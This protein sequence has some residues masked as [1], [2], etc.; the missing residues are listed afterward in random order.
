MQVLNASNRHSRRECWERKGAI[1]ND[2]AFH[3]NSIPRQER[4]NAASQQ[5]NSTGPKPQNQ[6]GKPWSPHKSDLNAV[7]SGLT[8]CPSAFRRNT[9][10]TRMLGTGHTASQSS[11]ES[12]GE[13]SLLS[14]SEDALSTMENT[15]YSRVCLCQNHKTSQCTLLCSKMINTFMSFWKTDYWRFPTR[16]SR[17]IDRSDWKGF[18]SRSRN[19]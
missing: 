6:R 11:P 15:V 17:Q 13:L 19:Y 12:S 4:H 8:S 2:V 10:S 1:L 16:S 3:T 7:G 9:W 14:A 5:T 18:C